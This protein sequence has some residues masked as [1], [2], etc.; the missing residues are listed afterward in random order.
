M[1]RPTVRELICS[2]LEVEARELDALAAMVRDGDIKTPRELRE[3]YLPHRIKALERATVVFPKSE[4][5]G[6]AK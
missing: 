6:E 3:E 2:R 4:P 5:A 1:S